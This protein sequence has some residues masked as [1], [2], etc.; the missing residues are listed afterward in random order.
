MVGGEGFDGAGPEAGCLAVGGREATRTPI[1][2]GARREAAASG[3]IRSLVRRLLASL[4]YCALLLL[5]L[6]PAAGAENDGRGFYGATNDKVV[7][8]AGFI[9]I[10]FFPTFILLASLLQRRLEKRKD[11]RV[12]AQRSHAGDPR[13]RGG[14]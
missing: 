2:A 9:L 12:A 1:G 6:A 8:L 11:A 4:S 7:T 3:S 10:V 5:V 14:W 13:W